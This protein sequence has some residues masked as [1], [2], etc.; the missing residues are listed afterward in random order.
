MYIRSGYLTYY[1]INSLFGKKSLVNLGL[2]I[3]PKVVHKLGLEEAEGFE[4]SVHH[5]T[6]V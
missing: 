5:C 1:L 6:A 4:P 3:W 2:F